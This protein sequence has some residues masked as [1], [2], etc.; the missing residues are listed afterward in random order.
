MREGRLT[1][2]RNRPLQMRKQASGGSHRACPLAA[3]LMV[4]T[5]AMILMAFGA[6]RSPSVA[7]A[8]SVQWGWF[9]PWHYS[10]ARHDFV[11]FLF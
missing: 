10:S 3:A 4:H 5:F 2:A 7:R 6:V 9:K 8:V 1:L 11:E